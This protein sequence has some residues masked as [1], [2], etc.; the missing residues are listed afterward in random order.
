MTTVHHLREYEK[1][2]RAK[3]ARVLAKNCKTGLK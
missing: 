3:A 2:L 1:Q